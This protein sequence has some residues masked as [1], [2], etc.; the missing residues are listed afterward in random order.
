M[1]MAAIG[2]IVA[3]GNSA[4]VILPKETLERHHLQKGDT[5]H[6][7]D[8]PEGILIHPY[9]E[10]FAAKMEVASDIV[11]RYRDAFKKLAE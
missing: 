5:V 1:Y 10:E 11:R 3:I 9:D 8:G 6:F 4:G 2:K 7:S